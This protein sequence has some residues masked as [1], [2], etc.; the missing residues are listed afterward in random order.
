[1]NISAMV[2]NIFPPARGA[3]YSSVISGRVLDVNGN[4]VANATVTASADGLSTITTNSNANGIYA[5]ILPAGDYAFSVSKSGAVGSRAYTVAA[6]SQKTRAESDGWGTGVNNSASGIDVTVYTES[7]FAKSWRNNAG[8]GRFDNAQNWSGGT[9]PASG[10]DVAVFVSGDTVITA[11]SAMTV[12]T[13]SVPSGTVRFS[14]SGSVITLGGV[15]LLSAAS[16]VEITGREGLADGGITGVGT[17]VINPG[18]GNTYTMPNNNTN[19]TGEAVIKSGTTPTAE[20]LATASNWSCTDK[21][22]AYLPSAAPDRATLSVF[23]GGIGSVTLPDGYTAPW[24]AR[25]GGWQ[26]GA[27]GYA[28]RDIFAEPQQRRRPCLRVYDARCGQ[29]R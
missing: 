8:D 19:F 15:N 4:P 17:L 1:M 12:G 29:L 2:A 27:S 13:V 9:L 24:G 14:G 22:G 3:R 25:K 5:F 18:A 10:Q 21:N 26:R 23:P 20:E 16:T 6:S 28:V 11:S 7:D